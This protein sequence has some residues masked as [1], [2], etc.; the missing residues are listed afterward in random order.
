MMAILL[1]FPTPEMVDLAITVDIISK[2]ISSLKSSVFD[3][4][5]QIPALFLRKTTAV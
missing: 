3:T 2:A 5:D 4:P 1:L